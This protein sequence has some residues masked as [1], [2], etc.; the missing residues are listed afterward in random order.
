MTRDIVQ[1]LIDTYVE[2]EIDIDGAVDRLTKT[3]LLTERQ[4]EAIVRAHFT[5]ASTEEI[6]DKRGVSTGRVY[7]VRQDVEEKLRMAAETLGIIGNLRREVRP[8]RTE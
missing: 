2:N 1:T 8:D 3:G 5:N 7:N 4:A 6:A